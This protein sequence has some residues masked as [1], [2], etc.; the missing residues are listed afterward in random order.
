MTTRPHSG[1]SL[2]ARAARMA[3]VLS[4]GFVLSVAAIAP[5]APAEAAPKA[6]F[7]N[8]G[9]RTY[10]APPSTTTAPGTASPLQRT[11]APQPGQPRAAQ[12]GATG[13]APGGL[14][15]GMGGTLLKGLLI[16][17]L[18]GALL[19]G[20][21]GGLAGVLGLILQVAVIGLGIW[22]VMRLIRS[23]QQPAAAGQAPMGGP[24]NR[25]MGEPTPGPQAP[26]GG[27]L[28]G[29]NAGGPAPAGAT[30]LGGHAG[31]ESMQEAPAPYAPAAHG[32]TDEIGLTGEDFEA[33]ERL[34]G[35][36]ETAFGRGDVEELKTLTTMDAHRYLAENIAEIQAAGH[37]TEIRD[38]QLL[39]GD[40][41]EAWRE[42]N[43]EYA[44]VAMRFSMIDVTRDRTTGAVVDGDPQRPTELTQVWT[45]VRERSFNRPGDWRL[46]AMQDA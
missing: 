2:A 31:Y 36:V 29:G 46:S 43:V 39:Q 15:G 23:R 45:F 12:P 33:F 8:R 26:M 19:G 9:T 24:L 16:G 34:L 22:F 44:S 25:G 37:V 10:Q 18:I 13:A 27:G 11:T 40:L 3:A 35:E 42:G 5:W 7:G 41:A 20:G 4:F 38:V 30:A 32:P 21:F 17:G 1:K 28:F 14:F 6:G